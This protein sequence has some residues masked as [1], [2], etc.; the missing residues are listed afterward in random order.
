MS[1]V[2]LVAREDQEPI[3]RMGVVRASQDLAMSSVPLRRS[4]MAK[5]KKGWACPGCERP[6]SAGTLLDYKMG[7]ELGQVGKWYV[8]GRCPHCGKHIQFT[9]HGAMVLT[10]PGRAG[11][12]SSVAVKH[13]RGEY[14]E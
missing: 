6:V 11:Y 4:V 1:A 2:L 7:G 9:K 3:Y 5:R 10:G 12:P 13:V 8:R 14:M